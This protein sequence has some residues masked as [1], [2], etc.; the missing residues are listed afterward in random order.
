MS[1][2][3]PQKGE[4]ITKAIER[5]ARGGYVLREPK[6][7]SLGEKRLLAS[8]RFTISIMGRPI[9]ITASPRSGRI[10]PWSRWKKGQS[11]NPKGRPPK[12]K[13]ISD[14]MKVL[15]ENGGADQVARTLMQLVRN[16]D[17]GAVEAARVLLDRTEG[18]VPKKRLTANVDVPITRVILHD[19]RSE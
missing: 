15:I 1:D 18:T 16:G 5:I 12:R 8:G 3:L 7:L 19:E 17:R 2:K 9:D 6:P 10:P 11:G 14:A 13:T 4:G